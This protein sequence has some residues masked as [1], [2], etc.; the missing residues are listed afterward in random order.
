MDVVRDAAVK[1]GGKVFVESKAGRGSDRCWRSSLPITV[2]SP[3]QGDGRDLQRWRYG[4]ALDTQMNGPGVQRQAA[5][6]ITWR[7]PEEPGSSPPP[8]P[9]SEHRVAHD[10]NT[11]LAASIDA[12]LL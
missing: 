3:H 10:V 1:L 7:F 11:P 9:P 6:T 5:V 4:L 12:R 8:A 2:K